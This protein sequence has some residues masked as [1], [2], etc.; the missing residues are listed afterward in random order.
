MINPAYVL[1]GLIPGDIIKHELTK[2]KMSE[3]Q[4]FIKTNKDNYYDRLLPNIY[5]IQSELMSS[6][7]EMSDPDET[8]IYMSALKKLCYFETEVIKYKRE[9]VDIEKAILLSNKIKKDIY[10]QLMGLDSTDIWFDQWNNSYETLI[11]GGIIRDDIW[12]RSKKS[13]GGGKDAPKIYLEGYWTYREWDWET[14]S[15][16]SRECGMNECEMNHH[17]F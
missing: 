11:F 15:N 14:K 9:G 5:I 6:Y 2:Y 13:C 16:P 1:E 17:H 7:R 12:R 3:R 4:E 8:E 10:E